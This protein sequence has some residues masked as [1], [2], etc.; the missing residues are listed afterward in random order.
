MP[1]ALS[2]HY[3][4][5]IYFFGLT[6]MAIGLPV[7]K[8]LMSL[9]Q[10]ILIGNW[11]LEGNIG[12]KFRKFWQNKSAVVLCSVF[13]LH[14]IGLAYTSDFKYGFEDVRKKLPLLIL[15]FILSSSELLSP[16]QF[17]NLM[18]L[19]VLS[20]LIG[21]FFSMAVLWGFIHRPVIDIRDISLFVS[22]IRFSLMICVAILTVAYF[23][24]YE[25][26]VYKKIIYTLLIAWLGIFLIIL[27]SLTGIISLFIIV[28]IFL[29]YYAFTRE[30]LLSKLVYLVVV[31]M[32]LLGTVY[33]LN[34]LNKEFCTGET[35]DTTRLEKYTSRHNE[36]LHDLNNMDIENGHY[37]W[38]YICWKELEEEWNK[39]SAI[40]FDEKD[41]KGNEIKYTLIRFITSKGLRKDADGVK[42]LTTNDIEAIEK[43]TAN[44]NRHG[45]INLNARI[46]EIFWEIEN[47]KKGGNPNGHSLTQ[48]FEYWKTALQI[49]K[50][51]YLLGVGTGDVEN[52]FEQEYNRENSLLTQQW[53]LR[54]H[55]QYLSITVAFGL[56]GLMWFLFSLIY[57]VIKEKKAFDYF[58]A[59]FFIIVLS[60]MLTEDTLETQAG[61]SFFA[62]FNSLFLFGREKEKN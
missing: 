56:M 53:R 35:P 40:K 28:F 25:K 34:Y 48:R 8:F 21:T 52:A 27:E 45:I 16:K 42:A 26:A 3:H 7:S 32:I 10:I 20:V 54:S 39:R 24:Y 2:S 49:I 13:I 19:F 31:L 62:F 30:K 5:S 22:H 4:R 37:V 15:P 33:Y 14:L 59:A 57:P 38:Q 29:I 12:G 47:Y 58:Y 17:K 51:N 43:G 55:N 11:L 6:L 23:L 9:S 36:Y 18:M 1:I 41:K 61:V 50:E 60:S 44:V 46:C